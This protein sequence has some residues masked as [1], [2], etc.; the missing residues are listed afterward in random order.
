MEFGPRKRVTSLD[1]VNLTLG[2][3][4]L[5]FGL[6]TLCIRF[7]NPAM[8]GKLEAMKKQW[9]DFAG[10]A[11]HITAYTIVPIVAGVALIIAGTLGISFFN[12]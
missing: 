7:A 3:F 9:G 4:A 2:I 8:F 5:G 11:I 1:P 10:N 12:R 6:L